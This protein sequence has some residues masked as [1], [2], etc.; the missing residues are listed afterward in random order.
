MFSCFKSL[1][2]YHPHMATSTVENYLKHM[3][4]L[5]EGGEELVSMGALAEALAGKVTFQRR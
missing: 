5:S 1:F 2:Y 3:L 4:L